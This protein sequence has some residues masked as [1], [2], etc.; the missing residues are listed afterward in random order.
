MIPSQEGFIIIETLN[1]SAIFYFFVEKPSCIFLNNLSPKFLGR[2]ISFHL[3]NLPLPFMQ[4]K[5][6]FCHYPAKAL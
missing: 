4:I 2:L 1:R 3:I 6:L 5:H